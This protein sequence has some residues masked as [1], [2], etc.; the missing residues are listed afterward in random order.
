[1]FLPP[2][3]KL[4]FPC[5]Q[6]DS[7]R[8][9][10]NLPLWLILFRLLCGA[11]ILIFVRR[12]FC[13]CRIHTRSYFHVRS[14]ALDKFMASV[15]KI[16]GLD[17]GL[18]QDREQGDSA[19]GAENASC[20]NKADMDAFRVSLGRYASGDDVDVA[21]FCDEVEAIISL[22]GDSDLTEE[23]RC[24]RMVDVLN[25]VEGEPIDIYIYIYKCMYASCV[26]T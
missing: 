13:L 24:K 22:P 4:D 10:P 20:C 1:M 23:R 19:G 6:Y 11:I 25:C 21:R 17:G 26:G 16:F 15:A 7:L 2:Y 8:L 9:L 3:A 5:M 12:M 14:A 18:E